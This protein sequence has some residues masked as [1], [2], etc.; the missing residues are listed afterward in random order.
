MDGGFSNSTDREVLA[1]IED[2]VDALTD[3]RLRLPTNLESRQLLLDAVQVAGRLQTWLQQ[4]AGRIDTTEAAWREHKTSAG[5]WLAEAARLTPKEARHL[6]KAGQ[7]LQREEM[8][9]LLQQLDAIKVSSHCPHGRPLW[10][11]IPYGDIR[12]SFRRPQ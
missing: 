1:V 10:R 6:I 9:A 8:Q 11:L 4:L 5:T 3:D 12:Q 2:A 7:E